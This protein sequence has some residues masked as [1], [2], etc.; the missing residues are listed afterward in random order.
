VQWNQDGVPQIT[1]DPYP[2]MSSIKHI[3]WF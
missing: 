3:T 2:Q 1:E